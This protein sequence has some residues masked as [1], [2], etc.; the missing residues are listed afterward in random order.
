MGKCLPTISYQ[1]QEERK[2]E[3]KYSSFPSLCPVP[4]SDTEECLKNEV[5]NFDTLAKTGGNGDTG[6]SR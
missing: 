1:L 5:V 3:P 4:S 6:V 2:C